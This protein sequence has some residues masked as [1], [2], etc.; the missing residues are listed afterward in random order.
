MSAEAL[1]SINERHNC[2]YS[3]SPHT[4]TKHTWTINGD[5]SFEIREAFLFLCGSKS[6]V[7]TAIITW[8]WD[9]LYSAIINCQNKSCSI[10]LGLDWLSCGAFVWNSLWQCFIH[11]SINEGRGFIL[12]ALNFKTIKYFN[13]L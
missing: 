4:N 2:C 8:M 9:P 1:E 13:H 7:S 6:I 5:G 12:L 3:I 11:T 10:G